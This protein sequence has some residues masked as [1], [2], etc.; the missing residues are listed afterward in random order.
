MK[1]K[2]VLS[3]LA[4]VLLLIATGCTPKA[5]KNYAAESVT[6]FKG[7][8]EESEIYFSGDKWRVESER[9]GQDTIMIVR[10]DKGVA[11][12]L[13]PQQKMYMETKLKKDMMI[14]KTEKLPGEVKREK[15]GQEK[16]SG[17]P[18]TKYLITYKVEGQEKPR[19]VYQW[20]SKDKIAMKS[21]GVDGSWTTEYVNIKL[22]KQPASLFELPAGYKKFEMPT[23]IR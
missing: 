21:A 8:T 1:N 7:R 14:G 12:L 4:F 9:R 23:G 22:G 18:C 19:Q 10:A 6:K 20:L 11:W 15:V 3:I 5:S 13:M 2:L 17:I 16:V